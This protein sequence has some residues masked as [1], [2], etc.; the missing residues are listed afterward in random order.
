MLAEPAEEARALLG[1][2]G[3]R[4]GIAIREFSFQY[5]VDDDRQLPRRRGQ[6]LGLADAHS[7]SAIERA[8]CRVTAADGH[9]RHAERHGRA[10]GGPLGL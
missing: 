10:I 1:I 5:A 7:Q 9:G 2:V 6:R 3:L 8:E 4:P